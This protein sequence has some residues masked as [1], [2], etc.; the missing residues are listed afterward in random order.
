MST[1]SEDLKMS[2]VNTE[3]LYPVVELYGAIKGK[4]D[5]V[6]EGE[7]RH[8]KITVSSM[9]SMK[10]VYK[11]SRELFGEWIAAYVKMERR[12]RIGRMGEILL[13]LEYVDKVLSGEGISIYEDSVPEVIKNDPV[14]FGVFLKGMFLTT[15][16]ISMKSSYHMEFFTDISENYADDLI[17]VFQTLA[18]VKA[19]YLIKNNKI[20]L[21]IKS[22][23]DI[24]NV[25]E[26]MQ[27]HRTIEKLQETLRVRYLKG[28]VSRTINF[29][30]ANAEKTA[31]SSSNQIN[32]INYIKQTVGLNSLDEKSQIIARYRL[33]NEEDS[34]KD[35]ADAL[36]MSKSTL[37]NKLKKI[38]EIAQEIRKNKE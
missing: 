31:Q 7:N 22:S 14:K 35:M 37:Y 6:I 8:L 20:K 3:F 12:L 16:S 24:I 30:S 9:N 13:N 26:L 33:E 36:G 17:K 34:L 4:G 19:N 1:F 5:F 38:S 18:G 10:R 25:L 15:G 32:D 28:S 21:Y 2:L 11:L 23:Q 27:A 29:I